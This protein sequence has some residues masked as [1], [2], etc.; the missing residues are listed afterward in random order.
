MEYIFLKSDPFK[1]EISTTRVGLRCAVTRWR[2][3][4]N[5]SAS[6]WWRARASGKAAAEFAITRPGITTHYRLGINF[7]VNTVTL[8]GSPCAVMPGLLP[9]EWGEAEEG[10]PGRE[11]DLVA[12]PLSS[13]VTSWPSAAEGEPHHQVSQGGTHGA[14]AQGWFNAGPASQTLGQHW[15]NIGWRR[16][17]YWRVSRGAHETHFRQWD[18][19]EVLFNIINII[20][21]TL[22]R[23]SLICTRSFSSFQRLGSQE[24]DWSKF[25]FRP[26]RF[27]ITGI[28][29]ICF[30]STSMLN[31]WTLIASLKILLI[32][33]C[34]SRLSVS[35]ISWISPPTFS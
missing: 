23:F 4:H 35:N 26:I 21:I 13:S 16:R 10:A 30:E 2:C 33:S 31:I 24:S 34:G 27:L 11:L 7:F 32:R 9:G 14:T 18:Y 8:G 20:A 1:I 15:T 28:V 17:V 5:I 3:Y 25:R 22:R 29:H 12:V 19:L 6:A